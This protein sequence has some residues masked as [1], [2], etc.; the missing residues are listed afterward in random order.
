MLFTDYPLI[1]YLLALFFGLG[2]GSYATMPAYR[3]PRGEAAGGRW[4]GPRSKCP[5]CDTQLRTRDLVPVFNW[6]LTRGRCH[7]CGTKV[8]LNYLFIE[9]SCAAIS[10][11][12]YW[13]FGFSDQYLLLMGLGVCLVIL[14]STDWHHRTLPKQILFA[15]AFFGVMFRTLQ[16]GTL[17]YMVNSSVMAFLAAFAVKGYIEDKR[18][19]KVRRPDYLW[20]AAIAGIWLDEA[21]LLTTLLMGLALFGLMRLRQRKARYGICFALPLFAHLM[22]GDVPTLITHLIRALF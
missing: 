2:C 6:L 18:R 11:L 21:S 16:D 9:A 8:S 15:I 12:L 20:F 17:F 7:F 14:L 13:R 10:P 3:L 4:V 22:I 19:K 1:G 5:T